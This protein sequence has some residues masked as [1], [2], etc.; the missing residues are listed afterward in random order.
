MFTAKF[1]DISLSP[2][3]HCLVAYPTP[4]SPKP[5]QLPAPAPMG[6]TKSTVMGIESPGMVL[7][8]RSSRHSLRFLHLA[9]LKAGRPVVASFAGVHSGQGLGRKYS[10]Q[11]RVVVDEEGGGVLIVDK[12]TPFNTNTRSHATHPF[13][14]KNMGSGGSPRAPWVVLESQSR[15]G[16]ENGR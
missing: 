6:D 10:E 5:S 12:S 1:M 3:P 16:E 9:D 11:V 2:C 14:R 15:S 8:E 13:R 7:V 4:L